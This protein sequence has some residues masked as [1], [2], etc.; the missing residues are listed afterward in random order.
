MFELFLF[1]C[2]F[3]FFSSLLRHNDIMKITQMWPS[4]KKNNEIKTEIT[5]I[6]DNCVTYSKIYTKKVN[7]K[8]PT[9]W[10]RL[11]RSEK[12][13]EIYIHIYNNY[14]KLSM[15]TQFKKVLMC[16]HNFRRWNRKRCRKSKSEEGTKERRTEREIE[17]N[18]GV[19]GQKMHTYTNNC[20]KNT[21]EWWS[22]DGRDGGWETFCVI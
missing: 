7:R 8:M 19:R 13:Y 10:R 11:T 5:T 21:F 4:H 14:E 12:K 15:Q 6:H 9:N 17:G 22:F 2:R 16:A 18:E 3:V 1:F 20:W